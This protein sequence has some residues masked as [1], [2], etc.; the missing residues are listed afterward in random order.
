MRALK[1][2]V[3]G[4]RLDGAMHFTVRRPDPPSIDDEVAF[5]RRPGAYLAESLVDAQETHMSWV[6]LTGE[7]AYKLKKPV[8]FP[9]L[10]FSTLERRT[11]ACREELRLNRRLARDVYLGMA[12]LLLRPQGFRLGELV[13][14]GPAAGALEDPE[15]V[16]WLVVMRRLDRGRM[17]EEL[18]GDG[19]SEAALSRLSD[20]LASFYRHA[21]RARMTAGAL[22]ARHRLDL[23]AA[24]AVLLDSRLDAPRGL[25]RRVLA[26]AAQ[27]GARCRPLMV[28]R[29][30]RGRIVDGHGDLRPEHI[31]LGDGVLVIDALEFNASLRAVDPLEEIAFLELECTRLKSPSIGLRIKRKILWR[32]A[33]TRP[34]PLYTWYRSQKAVQ[35]ARLAMAHLLE[36]EPRKPEVWP[37][38][39]RAYLRSALADLERLGRALNR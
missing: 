33:E 12:P 32:L 3:P 5:L 16:D 30:R 4:L 14:D 20:R 28:R 34:E 26:L 8:R 31:W 2:R 23:K 1:A 38:R 37:V 11:Q 10:D 9:Y 7:R 27:A 21:P 25:V 19:V 6:F 35:R 17:L 39:T 29:T 36:P 13:P 18:L 22:L 24:R 15:I